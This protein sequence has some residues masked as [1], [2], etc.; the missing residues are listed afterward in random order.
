MSFEFEKTAL[1]GVIIAAPHNYSGNRGAP[2]EF[3]A[4]SA[5]LTA[6]IDDVFVQKR[7]SISSKGVLR[8]IHTQ[9]GFPQAKYVTVANGSVFDVIVD[10][11]FSSPTFGEFITLE[12]NMLTRKGVYIPSGCSRGFLSLEDNT[13]VVFG[14]PREYE[15]VGEVGI[16]WAF[17][18]LV[19]PWPK[20]DSDSFILCDR[21]QRLPSLRDEDTVSRLKKGA[22]R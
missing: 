11:R 20:R 4:R 9:E 16:R 22:F 3:Y 2:R 12:L 15:L 1:K 21:D 5:F 19:I 6:W 8:G 14:V 7:E 17:P 10:M 18:S 13:R